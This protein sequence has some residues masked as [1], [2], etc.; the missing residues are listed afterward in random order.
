MGQ[1]EIYNLLK[2]QPRL[3]SREIAGIL[4]I[5][6]KKV[7]ELLNKMINKDIQ[8]V[9]PTEKEYNNLLKKY[10]NL[11]YTS[12]HLLAYNKLRLFVIK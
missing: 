3:C 11:K 7:S 10:P 12:N 8:I 4:N 6:I 5:K 9:N 2:E 1:A